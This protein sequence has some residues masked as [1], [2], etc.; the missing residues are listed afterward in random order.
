ME[1]LFAWRNT[2]KFR[3]FFHYTEAK[4]EDFNA[5]SQTF[6]RDGKFQKFRYGIENVRTG[7]LL[8]IIF[9]HSWQENSCY[10]NIFLAEQHERKGY[11]T[12]ACSLLYV[13]LFEEIRIQKLFVEIFPYNLYSLAFARSIGLK[14]I[15]SRKKK[16]HAGIEYDVCRFEGDGTTVFEK[17][18]KLKTMLS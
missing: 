18:K 10:L 2:E 14:E 11:G 15:G 7:E 5:F 12:D 16:V 3:I 9:T 13:F 4:E 17:M 1:L 6:V 8:G